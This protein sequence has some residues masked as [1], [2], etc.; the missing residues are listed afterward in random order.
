[1]NEGRMVEV[2]VRTVGTVESLA[3]FETS[4]LLELLLSEGRTE[5]FS[6]VS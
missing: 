5:W 3:E 1:M 4:F 6:V 2:K